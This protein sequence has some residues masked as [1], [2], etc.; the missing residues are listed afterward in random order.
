MNFLVYFSH[1]ILTS[2]KSPWKSISAQSDGAH[3]ETYN[4]FIQDIRRLN[5]IRNIFAHCLPTLNG[6]LSYYNKNKKIRE[7]RKLEELHAEFLEKIKKISPQLN[8]IFN[9]LVEEN[10]K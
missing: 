4:E 7:T 5:N 6:S 2:F 1:L 10:K 8:K 3:F 9:K